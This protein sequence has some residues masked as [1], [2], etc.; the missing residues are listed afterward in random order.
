[1]TYRKISD[2]L[3]FSFLFLFPFQTVL[4]LR[5]PLI[6][7]EKWQYGTIG[8]Y[9]TDILLFLAIVFFVIASRAKQSHDKNSELPRSPATIRE[10]YRL[11]TMTE[12]ILSGLLIWSG[13]SILWASDTALAG[14]FFIK[15]VLAVGVFFLVRS[16][17]ERERGIAMNVLITA[18]V[19]QSFLAIWQFLSQDTFSSTW[20]GMSAHHAWEAGSSVLKLDSGRFLRAYGTFPHPNML[21]GF[22]GA[23]LVIMIG[24]ISDAGCKMQDEKTNYRNPLSLISRPLSI[25]PY[26]S[27]S[28][29]YHVSLIT[30]HLSLILILLGLILTFSRTAWLG[31]ALGII[32]LVVCAYRSRISEKNPIPTESRW[33]II[34][35]PWN[36]V[37]FFRVLGVLGV[38]G[39]IFVSV[40]HEQIFPR[41]DST[42]IEKEGSINERIVSLQDAAGIIREHPLVGVGAGNFTAAILKREERGLG[43]EKGEKKKVL[44]PFIARPVWSIQP[45]HNVFVLVWAELGLVGVVLFSLFVG[46]VFYG[47]IASAT[48][49]SQCK[50]KCR[51]CRGDEAPPYNDNNE[52]KKVLDPFIARTLNT[53]N[54]IFAIALL[55]LLPSLFLDHWLWSSHFGLMFLFL[56]V[57]FL[58]SDI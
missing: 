8:V 47:V 42:T 36:Y 17:S 52:Q 40:L 48:K 45:A 26:L 21:G 7:G 39:V 13:L 1:M 24:K 3:I 23:V 6:G 11:I 16:L 55:T 44:D 27:S 28:I 19:L 29:T 18:A 25:T 30:Y 56:F 37:P 20:L 14:Y 5:E 41:F 53:Q 10:S 12:W 2:Y 49:Q 46:S 43:G 31:T 9:G 50:D 38:S 33:N 32:V 22:L 51:D 34:L 57:G 4:L 35:R 15:L 58:T 54:V